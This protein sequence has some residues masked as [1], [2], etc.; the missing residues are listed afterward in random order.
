MGE[1]TGISW[2][3]HTFNAWWGCTKVSPAC[4]RCYAETWAKRTGF[5]IWGQDAERR[6]F[7]DK[8]WNE[9]IRWDNA[10]ARDGVKRKVFWNSMSD[11][12]EDRRD[13]DRW[14]EQAFGYMR[15][16]NN[17]T[18][19]LLTK[20]PQNYRRFLPLSWQRGE[21]PGNIWCGTTVE[22]DAYYW[23]VDAL[24]EIP[25]SVRWLS[26]EPMLGPMS[27]LYEL[28]GGIGWVIVG[29]ESGHGARPMH[30]HWAMD[31][32]D[33]CV[34]AGVKFHFK[35]WGAW[36]PCIPGVRC[37]GCKLISIADGSELETGSEQHPHDA[38]MHPTSRNHEAKLD[39]LFWRQMPGRADHIDRALRVIK[40]LRSVPGTV[41]PRAKLLSD[42]GM[43]RNWQIELE[44][45]LS[46]EF[47]LNVDL[48]LPD[49]EFTTVN[50]VLECVAD[51]IE[52]G[53]TCSNA[54]I[55]E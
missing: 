13:L 50:H 36:V 48:R 51:A 49:Q 4:D 14:R 35:Q 22:T 3:D 33:Q 10:A 12:M 7:G 53:E 6:F 26:I 19:L 43:D 45:A 20:R 41:Q 39:G 38:Y 15:V 30:E 29:G 1:T 37:A 32:R 54:P 55:A 44:L 8:H 52:R 23:R 2:C 46:H 16:T 28:L 24:G 21:M 25:A 5:K 17:L 18:H 34:A 40:K 9:L 31:I 27:K 47:G 42:L 11:F